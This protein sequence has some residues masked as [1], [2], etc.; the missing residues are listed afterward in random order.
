MTKITLNGYIIVPETDLSAV[1][2]ALITHTE[3]TLAETGCLT[4]RVTQD[5]ENP[6]KFSVYEKF[7]S[8]ESFAAHQ[9]RVKNSKWGEVAKNVERHYEITEG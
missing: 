8:K 9:T 2:H 6:L 4:F 7:E 3:L 1:K 5:S